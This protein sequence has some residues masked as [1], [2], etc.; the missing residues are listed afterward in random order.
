MFKKKV[1]VVEINYVP[2]ESTRRFMPDDKIEEYWR[3][4]DGLDG[5]KS[6]IYAMSCFVKSIF[7]EWSPVA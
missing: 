1:P 7:P 2:D 4:W 5:S 6:A 3:L